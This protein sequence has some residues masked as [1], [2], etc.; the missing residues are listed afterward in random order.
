MEITLSER[1]S[2]PIIIEGFP[3]FGLIGTIA[4]E[5][6]TQHLNTRLV[7]KY[8]FEEV[9]P[10]IAIHEGK[11]IHPVGIYH[12]KVHNILI[13][14]SITATPGIEWKAAD[15]VLEV[16]RM[17]NASEIISIEGVGTSSDTN[18][19]PKVFFHS[20]DRK[21]ES[22]LK[23]MGLTDLKEGIIVGVTSALLMK[24]KRKIT[25]LFAEAHS[26]LPDSKAAAEVVK[27][28]DKFLGIKVDTD[29]LLSQAEKLEG[30]IKDILT[31]NQEALD[32]KE[33]KQMNYVG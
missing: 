32:N 26:T 29:P 33:K 5:F 17:T 25:C 7:G 31:R 13:I 18:E 8:W 28:L 19:I 21:T 9:L 10:S 22:Q 30:K 6:L 27:V 12:D 23:A 2:K 14:H 3:G 11:M 20:S 1:I 4:T 16:A 15:L 24:A